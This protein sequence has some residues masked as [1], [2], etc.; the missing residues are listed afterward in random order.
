MPKNKEE[1]RKG[2]EEQMEKITS[3]ED[4]VKFLMDLA[5]QK[6]SLPE[7]EKQGLIEYLKAFFFPLT[8][9]GSLDEEK[10]GEIFQAYGKVLTGAY[11]ACGNITSRANEVTEDELKML[12][13]AGGKGNEAFKYQLYYDLTADENAQYLFKKDSLRELLDEEVLARSEKERDALRKAYPDLEKAEGNAEPENQKAEENSVTFSSLISGFFGSELKDAGQEKGMQ[14]IND[15]RTLSE[16]AGPFRELKNNLLSSAALKTRFGELSF[17]EAGGKEENTI[18]EEV[19]SGLNRKLQE[20]NTPAEQIGFLMDWAYIRKNLPAPEKRAVEK[21]IREY[22]SP[23]KENGEKDEEK[24][25]ERLKEAAM[26]LSTSYSNYA[27]LKKDFG[28]DETVLNLQ[29]EIREASG[30]Q[31]PEDL[32]QDLEDNI[33]LRIALSQN[34][35]AKYMFKKDSLWE[36]LPD[37]IV[38]SDAWKEMERFQALKEAEELHPDLGRYGETLVKETTETVYKKEKTEKIPLTDLLG[39]EKKESKSKESEYVK[40]MPDPDPEDRPEVE[41][42]GLQGMLGEGNKQKK[43]EPKKDSDRRKFMLLS[44]EEIEPKKKKP[45]KK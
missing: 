28:E 1:F 13:N 42:I 45:V 39:Q 12:Q 15:F 31:V 24:T 3:P 25:Q 35:K 5:F 6:D 17:E 32:R 16:K 18:D 22:F 21:S 11:E 34:E 44:D 27:A 38:K 14:I 20:L 4:K 19:Y 41:K 43:N 7:T 10:A 2:I 23:V 26:F 30:G 33:T 9:E 8:K 29:K 37:E 36:I 40:L